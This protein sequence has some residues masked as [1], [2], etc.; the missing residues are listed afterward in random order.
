MAVAETEI[1]GLR[2][3]GWGWG[4]WSI[5]LTL[6]EEV[7]GL[8]EKSR[9]ESPLASFKLRHCGH[10]MAGVRGPLRESFPEFPQSLMVG[11]CPGWQKTRTESEG[12]GAPRT[13]W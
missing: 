7:K 13:P 4:V 9:R 11:L 6:G 1:E 5:Q 3:R 8:E 10:V 12:L 2:F